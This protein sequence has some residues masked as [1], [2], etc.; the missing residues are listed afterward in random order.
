M[1]NFFLFFVLFFL[2][3]CV[4]SNLN[5]SIKPIETPKVEEPKKEEILANKIIDFCEHFEKEGNIKENEG[6]IDSLLT[7]YFSLTEE[8]RIAP[9]LQ[10][11]IER[12]IKISFNKSLV[13]NLSPQPVGEVESPKD[14]LLNETT[15][16]SKEEL[17]KTLSEV[18]NAKKTIKTGIAIPLE[19]KEVISYIGIYQTKLRNWFLDALKRRE[20]Y[21]EELMTIFKD[22]GVPPELINIAIVESAFRTNARS[23]ANAIGMWQ[24]MEQTGRKYDLKID[25][26]LDERLD[27]I[28]SA[29][30][31][32]KYLKALFD[33]FGDWNLALAS[34]NCGEGKILRYINKY[35]KKDFWTLRKSKFFKRETRE[36]V[37]A[38]LAAI[39]IA[40]DPAS[41]GFTLDDP[42]K[43]VE[44]AVVKTMFPIDL[45]GIANEL[46]IPIE[47]LLALNPSLKRI[48]TP[49]YEYELKVPAECYEKA[50]NYLSRGEELKAD[51]I[52]HKVRKRENLRTIAKK[53]KV[54]PSEIVSANISLPRRLRVGS[55]ILV[56]KNGILKSETKLV[57]KKVGNGQLEKFY[58]VKKGDTLSKIAKKYG[59]SIENICK[60]NGITPNITLKI[61]MKLK[62]P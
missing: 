42:P 34:Y 4:E 50:E 49:N 32:A 24:F 56:L 51:Y 25:F 39:T 14:I 53:Y 55:E 6:E 48:I 18:E 35:G 38:I 17:L 20:P 59:V 21:K 40:T 41:F 60:E 43:K 2:V 31:S 1:K 58:F 36:Y 61:G 11:A 27:P 26:F 29:R 46:K 8:E 30:A 28:K 52:I 33:M 47:Y 22:E 10:G 5:K 62:I 45:R 19:K 12:L 9:R 44:Y 3:S 16:L 15:F 7:Q 57:G 23:R 13:E 37:P 54:D